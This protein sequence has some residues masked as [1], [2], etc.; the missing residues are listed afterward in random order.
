VTSY[1]AP[2]LQDQIDASRVRH[3]W[4]KDQLVRGLATYSG[5]AHLASL[6]RVRILWLDSNLSLW[7]LPYEQLR[8]GQSPRDIAEGPVG[9]RDFIALHGMPLHAGAR[10][11]REAFLDAWRSQ[12]VMPGHWY[13]WSYVQQPELDD[14]ALV[15]AAD[16]AT[17]SA[18][19]RLD[20]EPK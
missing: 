8:Q 18:R 10:A 4:Y 16:A 3:A 9:K 2:S 17:A 6:R 19:A 13:E 5:A 15:A 7:G 20:A 1:M 14:A 11:M 12:G